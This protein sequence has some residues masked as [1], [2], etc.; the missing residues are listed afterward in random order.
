MSASALPA[1]VRSRL[2]LVDRP[3]LAQRYRDALQRLNGRAT[4][5]EVFHVDA[6]G[7]SPDVATELGDPYYLGHGIAH[8]AFVILSVDQLD[9]PLIQPNA[10]FAAQP[11]RAWVSGL[12]PELA[13]LTL[14][15]AVYGEITHG[16]TRFGHPAQLGLVRGLSL[17]VHT[18]SERLNHALDLR[19][20]KT[21]LIDG[22]S[23]WRDE[24]F[25][26]RMVDCAKRA[27]GWVEVPAG[28]VQGRH[29]QSG[30]SYV[31]AF[32]GCYVWPGGGE[33]QTDHTQPIAWVLCR[34][35]S[36]ADAESWPALA[37]SAGVLLLPLT[38]ESAVE[39]LTARKL[40]ELSGAADKF[41]VAAL[42]NL[43]HWLAIEHFQRQGRLTPEI[44]ADPRRAMRTEANPPADYLELEDLMLRL[45]SPTSLVDLSRYTPMTRLRA[46]PVVATEPV[47]L[48]WVRHLK[49]F[50]DPVD[51]PDALRYA[52][53][54][55]LSL[56]AGLPAETAAAL[57]RHLSKEAAR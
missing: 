40:A 27:H 46:M 47:D 31:P 41:D 33:D 44:A 10:G 15:E 34:A 3:L 5:L 18:P 8:P 38:A 17:A 2:F 9:A 19:K 36:S 1:A 37:E 51:L 45:Q 25:L 24:A 32:G 6:A 20:M 21:E 4:K 12:R 11:F 28:L 57:D 52:P 13:D 35:T 43:Q 23:N 56:L 26:E 42:N 30:P 22:E 50:L 49:A 55:T 53:D 54:L 7:Y 48:A 14:R 39:F 29:I 16:V